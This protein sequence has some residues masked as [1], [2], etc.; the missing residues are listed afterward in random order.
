M[1]AAVRLQDDQAR[2]MSSVTA[3]ELEALELFR[4]AQ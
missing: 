3:P 4:A 1:R 2:Q